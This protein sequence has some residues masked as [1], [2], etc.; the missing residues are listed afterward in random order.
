MRPYLKNI[1]LLCLL[2]LLFSCEGLMRNAETPRNPAGD[3]FIPPTNPGIVFQ[4]LE[5]AFHYRESTI[6]NR[7][8]ADSLTSGKNYRFE[9][10]MVKAV[11]FPP[12]WTV[13]DEEQ[14]FQQLLAACH[15]DSLLSLNITNDEI[16]GSDEGD[17]IAYQINYNIIA[18]HNRQGV[19]KIFNGQSHIKL[20]RNNHNYWVIY[21]WQDMALSSDATWSDLKTFF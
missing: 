19:D 15:S 18:R 8:F 21:Y 7:C 20:V 12:G 14:Y 5:N 2:P 4:N 13:N 10:A 3:H 6:Y 16:P 11:V 1:F 17:S 9:P